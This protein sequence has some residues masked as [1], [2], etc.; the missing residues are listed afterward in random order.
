VNQSQTDKGFKV[1][2]IRLNRQ[3]QIP[4][5]LRENL[6]KELKNILKASEVTRNRHIIFQVLKE[7]NCQPEFR[8]KV[9]FR[10]NGEEE[11]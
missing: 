2:T 7:K 8:K 4:L 9:S 5:K 6:G 3:L 11:E 1:I 10:N